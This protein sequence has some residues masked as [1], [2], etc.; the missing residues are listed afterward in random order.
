MDTTDL[1]EGATRI[2]LDVSPGA[3]PIRGCLR[4]ETGQPEPF[5]GWLE[6]TRVLERLV[7]E[8]AQRPAPPSDHHAP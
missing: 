7:S 6:L 8:A 4:S 3:R 2:V 1:D 5:T